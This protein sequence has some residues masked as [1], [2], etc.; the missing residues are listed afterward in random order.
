M[1]FDEANMKHMLNIYRRMHSSLETIANYEL[2]IQPDDT[3]EMILVLKAGTYDGLKAVAKNALNDVERMVAE[4]KAA[5][6]R[7]GPNPS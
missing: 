6:E 3:P 1:M 5:K 4:K 7:E 2:A